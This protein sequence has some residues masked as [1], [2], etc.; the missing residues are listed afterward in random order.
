MR[1]D[2][3]T[4][5]QVEMPLKFRFRTSFG[6]TTVK[7]FLLLELRSG[8]LSGWGECVAEEG[9]FY[10]PET[11][12]TARH[13]LE[14]FLLPLV[15]GHDV[16]APDEFETRA[17]R[18]RGN[19]MAKAAV[20]TALR[21]LV[22]RASGEPLSRALGGT[23]AKIEVGVSLGLSP[24]PAETVANVRR[25]V[26]QGYRRIKL[27]IEPGTDVDRVAAVREAFPSIPLT[28]DANAAYSLADVDRLRALDPFGLDYIEQ[29]L[30]H[31]DLADHAVLAKTLKTPICLDESIRSAADAHAAIALGACRVINVKVG[32]VGGHGEALRIHALASKAGV[33]LWC[34]GMLEAGVGRAH[35]V[36]I[37]S[38]PGFSK[39]GDTSSSS[40]YFEDDI[41]APP[42]EAAD[43]WMPVPPGSGIGV[44][45]R[46]DVLERMT[47]SILELRA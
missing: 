25:H 21:D 17:S 45:I 30:H 44:E 47:T 4:L 6:E 36:A 1:I 13:V 22:A 2:S 19:R 9:P 46:H 42:L 33:P 16:S 20:E 11:L 3:G 8:G 7:K 15:L 39:P 12:G 18:V 14:T 23:R 10:S 24:T 29:P 26:E 32:R 43:G 35:N 28:V 41:V 27:K 37:A 34:G 40:R 31:E 5:R 38:L